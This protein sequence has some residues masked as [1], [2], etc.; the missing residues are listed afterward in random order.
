MTSNSDV[1]SQADDI[2]RKG[3][4]ALFTSPCHSENQYDTL[5]FQVFE[6]KSTSLSSPADDGHYCQCDA[7]S[8]YSC[9]FDMSI[10]EAQVFNLSPSVY[11]IQPSPI[12]LHD[13][14]Y[15]PKQ[16]A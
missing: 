13:I 8:Y 7:C 14:D 3:E 4:Q 5:S 12:Y 6:D 11:L 16:F 1:E 15:P 2:V 9:A 10:F